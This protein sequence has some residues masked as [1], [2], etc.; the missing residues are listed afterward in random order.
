VNGVRARPCTTCP[1][2]RDVPPGIWAPA[3][4][5]RLRAYDEPT[6]GQPAVGFACH[7]D[8][9]LYCHGWAV[10]GSS[11]GHAFDLLALRI[12]PVEIPP[13]AVPLFPS[14]TAAADHG[15]AGAADPPAEARGRHRPPDP[16]ATLNRVCSPAGTPCR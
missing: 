9:A 4:Y 6:G 7:T 2:R 15:L 1:Y 3:E 5:D 16:P 13:A 11:R 14:A 8:P 12:D 10:V